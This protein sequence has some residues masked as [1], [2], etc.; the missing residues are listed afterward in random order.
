MTDWKCKCK[1]ENEKTVVCQIPK[2]A[3]FMTLRDIMNIDDKCKVYLYSYNNILWEGDS[4]KEATK[5]EIP[6]CDPILFCC[7]L[8][9][10]FHFKKPIEHVGDIFVYFDLRFD[11]KEREKRNAAEKI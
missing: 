4:I 8:R 3:D 6:I 10:E 7:E 2:A 9:L 5:I 1:L 11:K